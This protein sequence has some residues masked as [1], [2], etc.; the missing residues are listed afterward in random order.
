LGHDLHLGHLA[1]LGLANP[2]HISNSVAEWGLDETKIKPKV[3][4]QKFGILHLSVYILSPACG[5]QVKVQTALFEGCP[6]YPVF[7]LAFLFKS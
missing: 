5:W 2:G 6:K 1:H 3:Y 7:F 4:D